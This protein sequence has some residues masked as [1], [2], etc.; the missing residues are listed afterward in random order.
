MS[1]FVKKRDSLSPTQMIVFSFLSIIVTGTILLLRPWSTTGDNLNFIDALFTAVSATCV[2][3]LTVIDIG[4]E[5]TQFGQWVILI[6]IQVGG[7][8]IMTFSTFFLYL[9]G[10]KVSI[11]EREVLDTTLSYM[12]VSNIRSLLKKIVTMVFIIEAAGAVLLAYHW[13][14][15][16]P[17]PKAIYHG[18][19]HSISAFCNAGFSLYKNSFKDFSTDPFVNIVLIGLIIIGGLGFM[20][21][22]ELK[23]FIRRPAGSIHRLSFHSK[24]VLVVTAGLIVLGTLLL[25]GMEQAHLYTK[26]PWEQGLLKSVFQSV[27]ARTAGFNTIPIQSLSHGACLVLILLMFIGAAPG[28]C[29]GGVKVTTFGILITMIYSRLRGNDTPN[30]FFRTIPKETVEKALI[31]VFSSAILIGT[32]FLGLLVSEEWSLDPVVTRGH[33]LQLLFESVSAFGTVGLSMGVTPQLTTLGRVLII[34]LMFV[35]RIGP[36]TMALA[37]T[38]RGSQ[39]KFRFAKGEIMVG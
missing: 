28:S 34:I 20:V 32:I 14:G 6:L 22:F 9:I 15:W 2:T 24:V 16:Y 27:T 23:N 38:R 21:L 35:G 18:I 7:L 13:H 19:F 37:L 39:G 8:G 4:T 30:L 31:I 36:L 25:F 5:L 1:P 26:T 29:G 33:F 10:R 3:G 17:L 12:P 11:R